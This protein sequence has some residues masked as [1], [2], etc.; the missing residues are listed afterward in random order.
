MTSSKVVISPARNVQSTGHSTVAPL[1]E[2][3]LEP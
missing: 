2:D 1:P 3:E